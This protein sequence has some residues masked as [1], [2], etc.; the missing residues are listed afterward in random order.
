MNTVPIVAGLVVTTAG[1]FLACDATTTVRFFGNE[2]GSAGGGAGAESSG[3]NMSGRS[4][5]GDG[6][7]GPEGHGG[8]SGAS[9]SGGASAASGGTAGA[10]TGQGGASGGAGTWAVDVPNPS[11]LIHRYDFAGSDTQVPDLVG[12]ASGTVEGGAV[13][14]GDGTL[15]LDGDDD[16]VR[17]PAGL[18][19]GL[20]SV[21]IMV[22][23]TWNGGVAWERVFDF[24]ATAEGADAPGTAIAT[25]F[26]TPL[27]LS[28]PGSSAH[29]EVDPAYVSGDT[30]MIAANSPTAFPTGL[31]HQIVVVFDGSVRT[32]RSYIDGTLQGETPGD[33]A[34]S[35]LRDENCWLGQSMWAQDAHMHGTYD[36]FRLYHGALSLD[37]IQALLVAGPDRP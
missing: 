1:L 18:I 2:G 15:T 12:Q 22:W 28:G 31:M 33:L 37:E 36:E 20:E 27:F 32:L 29:F 35:D 13:L 4:A 8:G 24:G 16:Y 25:L 34:L 19:S 30:T 21:S 17:F 11:S 23:F 9:E 10:G 14:A 7:E 3:A 26:F 6:G 5:S